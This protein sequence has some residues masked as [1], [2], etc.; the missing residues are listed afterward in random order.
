MILYI[1][2]IFQYK[3]TKKNTAN[4]VKVV[5]EKKEITGYRIIII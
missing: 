5:R 3:E 2:E 4:E 1:F